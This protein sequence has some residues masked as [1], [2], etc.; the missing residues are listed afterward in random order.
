MRHHRAPGTEGPHD[1]T[2]HRRRAAAFR[3]RLRRGRGRGRQPAAGRRRGDAPAGQRRGRRQPAA[4]APRRAAPRAAD[5]RRRPAAAARRSR[6]RPA[7]PEEDAWFPPPVDGDAGRPRR[8]PTP[9]AAARPDAAPPLP[10]DPGVNA[11]WIGGP[12]A[13][14]GDCDY[15]EAFCLREDEGYPRGTC[16]LGCERTCPDRGDLPVTFCIGD[17]IV[18]A[19]ACVQRCD[20]EAFPQ[21]CRPG[22]HCETQ[23]RYSEPDTRRAVCLP[24][25]PPPDPAMGCYDQMDAAGLNYNPAANPQ[26][27]PDGRPDLVCDIV[28]PTRLS[29]PINGVLYRY[30][31]HDAPQPMFVSCD[32]ALALHQ[33]SAMLREYDIVE[34]GHIGTYNCRLIGGTD[35]LSMHGLARAIDLKWFRTSDGHVYDVEDHWEHDTENF[36]TEEGRFLFELGQQMFARRIFNIVLTPNYNAAHDNH[37]HVDLTPGQRFIGSEDAWTRYF[38]PNPHGD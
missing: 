22:Y 13:A 28:G 38:G 5:A 30:V 31:T 24:G 11:G 25:P 33:L 3:H 15:A 19:G 4:G 27:S 12:C 20:F 8:P 7:P 29:S 10:P 34:V 6:P 36:R 26:E 9:A 18:G 35:S 16:S 2:H 37:F 23:P 14:D 17:V 1:S 21:G 32:L